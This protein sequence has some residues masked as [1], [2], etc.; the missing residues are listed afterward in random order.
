MHPRGRLLPNDRRCWALRLAASITSG[1]STVRASSFSPRHY[2]VRGAI[3]AMERSCLVLASLEGELN[4]R[5][6]SSPK[7][8]T[9]ISSPRHPSRCEHRLSASSTREP[10]YRPGGDLHS[11]TAASIDRRAKAAV[12]CSYSLTVSL[13]LEGDREP[14]HRPGNR[15]L[16]AHRGARRPSGEGCCGMLLLAGGVTSARGRPC[17][18][19]HRPGSRPLSAHRGARRPSRRS[20]RAAAASHTR[21]PRHLGWGVPIPPR[22]ARCR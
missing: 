20:D 22:C 6:L 7:G 3:G 21:A 5:A 18:P 14:R 13:E 9:F 1:S 15:S 4:P 16:S 8:L 10:C 2:V 12:E 19:R 11:L 17:E